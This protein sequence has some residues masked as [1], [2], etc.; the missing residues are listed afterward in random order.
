[1]QSNVHE[2]A[3]PLAMAAIVA[4]HVGTANAQYATS[5][6]EHDWSF[7]LG[8]RRFGLQQVIVEPM[9]YRTTTIYVGKRYVK[10]RLLAGQIVT[11]VA[12]P[13]TMVAVALVVAATHQQRRSS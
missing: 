13:M 9:N 6:V 7:P 3:L 8:P 12:I 1:M 2:I 5:K 11:L 10:T 4:V